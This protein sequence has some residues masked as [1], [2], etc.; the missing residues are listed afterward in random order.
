[1]VIM[2]ERVVNTYMR[3]ATEDMLQNKRK[4]IQCPC[5]TC[6]LEVGFSPFTGDLLEHLLR[7]GFMDGHTRWIEDDENDGAAA[8]NDQEGQQ[9]HNNDEGQEDEEPDPQHDHV[10]LDCDEERVVPEEEDTWTPLTLVVRDP[11]L[12]ELFLKKTNNTQS[13]LAQLEI[14]SNTP[15]Y[16]GCGPE[17]SHLKVAL[18]FL[19]A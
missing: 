3:H 14:D 6:K 19:Q 7:R 12:K 10:G 18:D 5:Q 8:G 15:L 9:D 13:K 1:M 16:P 11:H 4:D 2:S 17:E